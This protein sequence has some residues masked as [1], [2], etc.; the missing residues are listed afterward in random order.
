MDYSMAPSVGFL[1]MKEN[2]G[3]ISNKGYEV[4]L[5]LMPY[6]NPSKEAYWNI[7]FTG[8]H[9]KSRIEQI[10]NALKVMNE[11][12]M[13]V[14]DEVENP[15]ET[16]I[17]DK[18]EK[19][20]LPRYE[21]GY[22]QTTIWAVRSMGID[23]QTGREVFLTRDGRLTNIY[24][25][26]DQIPV[27]DTEPKLQGSVSTTFTYKG[28]SLTLAGQ[29]HFGGQTYNKTLI[30]KVENANLR[31]NADRRALYSRWQ[32]PGDQVFFKAI[33]GNIYKT[34]TK[35]SSR[36]V[37][38]DNEFYFSGPKPYSWIHEDI[39]KFAF[40]SKAALS[41]IPTLGFR[42]DIIHCHDWQTGLVPVYLKERFAQGEFYQGVK[43]VMTIHNLKFQGIWDLKKVKDITGLPD[44]YFTSDKL[45]AYK[46]ANYLKGGIVYAD[47]VTTVS[48]T[49]AE[50]IKTPFYGEHLEGLM[51]ARSNCL[52][53]IVNGIDYEIY[54]PE[55]DENLDAKY[56]QITFRKEK[57]KNWRQSI[58][59]KNR[60]KAAIS[61]SSAAN[62]GWN[63]KT[64]WKMLRRNISV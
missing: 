29:Y 45:E 31:L 33:D 32:N 58:I 36:F 1:T 3:K 43:S 10:S 12:Q 28:F 62:C 15:Y 27:G 48:S 61:L 35:E 51:Q 21:N 20:P 55:T 54:N 6:S 49:Y 7:I 26:A 18:R 44:S 56:N 39:E 14:A 5:R 50:E 53:G 11:K 22:S 63:A 16:D 8:S 2:L 25:S 13:A 59:R 64:S 37:M 60:K 9:N 30:N 17:A 19:S 42:P 41:A 46:D 4:T 40:F 34:D 52:R 38:D 57:W 23:P 24:S 47:M